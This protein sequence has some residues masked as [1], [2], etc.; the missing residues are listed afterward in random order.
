M[1]S[2]GFTYSQS[3]V[4]PP[5]KPYPEKLR[6]STFN[7]PED[8]AS[9]SEKFD[10]GLKRVF[11]DD[12]GTQY[13]K[14]GG[15]RDNDFQHGIKGGKLTLTGYSAARP[16]FTRIATHRP[17]R[18]QVSGFFEPSVQTTVDVIRENITKAISKDLVCTS[19]TS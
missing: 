2:G 4:T 13:I 9:F 1:V 7:T 19:W 11:S 6:K 15:P 3:I 16:S 18:K 14:F 8:V 5:V 12:K 10:Q 17:C